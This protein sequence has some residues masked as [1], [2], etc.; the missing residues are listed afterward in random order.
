MNLLRNIKLLMKDSFNT[1][2]AE[3]IKES[4]KEKYVSFSKSILTHQVVPVLSEFVKHLISVKGENPE[5]LNPIFDCLNPTVEIKPPSYVRPSFRFGYS[6]TSRGDE[7]YTSKIKK[8]PILE[9]RE[10]L[11]NQKKDADKAV[12]TKVTK[13]KDEAKKPAKKT[14]SK[15][16]QAPKKAAKT[17]KKSRKK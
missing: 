1:D 15:K 12:L 10:K 4:I 9:S 16:V 14:S 17:T 7:V 2:D 13:I 5:S 11:E 6:P 3:E 8:H